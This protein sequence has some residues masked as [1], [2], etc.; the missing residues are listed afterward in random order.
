[1]PSIDLTTV[2]NETPGCLAVAHLN[3]A[4]SALPPRAVVDDV[5]DY[6]RLEEAFGGYEV[7]ER[8]SLRLER[9]YAA[10]AAL[11][12]CHPDELALTTNASEAWWRAFSSV[13]LAAGDRVLTGRAEY[14]SNAFG[15]MQAKA[16]G[17][18]V[19]VIPDDEQGQID[20]EALADAAAEG[21][22]LIAL[23]HVPTNSGLIN[24]AAEVGQ[25]A[26][27]SGAYFLLDACQS[28]GQL[29][30]DVEELQCDF[31]SFTG[32]KFLRGPRG[33][34]MLYVR[35]TMLADLLPP[36]FIDGRSADWTSPDDYE[37][38]PSAKRFELFESS[39]ANKTGLAT[40]IEYALGIG[41]DAIEDRV[42]GL[43]SHLRA[44][45]DAIDGV[46]VRDRGRRLSGIVTF[47]VIGHAALDVRLAAS[48]RGI[49][50]SHGTPSPWQPDA[51][52]P[53][54]LMVRASPHYY[55]TEAEIDRLCDLVV[56]FAT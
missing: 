39:F 18:D 11:L 22:K 30:V 29:R 45:L 21:V 41:I 56:E 23:T 53:G 24:P 14:V 7:A 25:I 27:S 32:R 34:G 36:S 3:N 40:A 10:G 33:T 12:G 19:H 37:L 44:Q 46:E 17:V 49:N 16:R 54:R 15:L 26:R 42:S 2:R 52:E 55:N 43:A 1:M 5:I 50:L 9:V 28:V 6:L 35:S 31:L 13:P 4:G 47:D 48:A 20:L 8:E 38:Q 51:P